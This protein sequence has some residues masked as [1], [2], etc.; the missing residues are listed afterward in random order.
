MNSITRKGMLS[1]VGLLVAGGAVVGPA[2]AVQAAPA[3]VVRAERPGGGER[4]LGIEYQAQPNG[5]YCGPAATRIALSVE[6]RALSQDEVA[7]RLGTTEAGTNSA[8]DVTRVLNE[9]T[10][11]GVYETTAISG[12]RAG[13]GDVERLRADVVGAVDDGRA[14]VANIKG[15]A[16]DAGGGRHSYEGGHYLSVVGYRDG[17]DTVKIADPYDPDE[18][19][20]MDVTRV[21]NWVAERGYS[22]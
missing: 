22:S 15:T 2:V 9:V 21:A 20:W 13:L 7:E 1:V 6:G 11:G 16:V 19:Y 3:S 17:G 10:G 8:E 5:Y 18:Q 14:V 4:V 12:S